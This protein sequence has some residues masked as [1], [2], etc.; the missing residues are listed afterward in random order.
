[1]T[2]DPVQLLNRL[3]ALVCRSLPQYLRSSRPYTTPQEHEAVDV[4]AAV[5]ADQDAMADRIC[6]MVTDAGGLPHT[7]KFPMEFTDLHDLGLDFLVDAAVKYQERDV[8]AIQQVVDAAEP[9]PAVRAI[10]E[11]TLGLA[12]GHLDTLREVAEKTP[13]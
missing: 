5:V 2:L 10:A 1:M 9:W 4:L 7:G 6:R 13:A 8:A 3:L 12:K 11:E